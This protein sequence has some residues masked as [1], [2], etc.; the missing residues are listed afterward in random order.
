MKHACEI[1]GHSEKLKLLT[2]NAIIAR[3]F[4]GRNLHIF[5]KFSNFHET[6][7]FRNQNL[8]HACEMLPHL[9]ILK[10][11]GK[12][13]S[14]PDLINRMQFFHIFKVLHFMKLTELIGIGTYDISTPYTTLPHN[15]IKEKLTELIEHT[16]KTGLTLFGL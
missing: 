10:L 4:T 3:T 5:S 12:M 8:K 13:A 1:W 14:E 15:L 9:E 2:K 16:F 7:R 6:C 11:L